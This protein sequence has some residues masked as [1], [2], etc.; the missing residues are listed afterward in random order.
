MAG[1]LDKRFDD[2]GS[3]AR[4]VGLG[5]RALARVAKARRVVPQLLATLTFFFLWVATTVKD[6]ALT[7]GQESAV[8]ERLIPGLYLRQAARKAR[9]TEDR[10]AIRA[11]A[12]GL[13][14]P[15]RSADGP[16]AGLPAERLRQI[17]QAAGDCVGLFQRSSSCVEGRNGHLA[18]WH[19]RLHTL[20]PRR[21]EALTVVHNHAAV[22]PDGK[23]PA[24]RFF[25]A[26]P[27]DIFEWLVDH[28]PLPPR[29]AR[30]RPRPSPQPV[31]AAA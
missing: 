24:E 15:L 1:L 21:L 3:V 28:V 6:L 12:E 9:T 31:L 23:T 17:E 5:E 11:V 8:R 27:D 2:L 7:P 14:G 20:R 22:G 16:L 25:G 26:K 10:V 18:L 19:H 13:L 30:K 29:P 4:D